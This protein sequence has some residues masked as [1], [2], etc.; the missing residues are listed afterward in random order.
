MSTSACFLWVTSALLGQLYHVLEVFNALFEYR[1]DILTVSTT[2]TG[3]LNVFEIHCLV[4]GSF[5]AACSL[6]LQINLTISHS[7]LRWVISHR[8]LISFNQLGFRWWLSSLDDNFV[9]VSQSIVLRWSM[10]P[11][12]NLMALIVEN[13]IR[14]IVAVCIGTLSTCWFSFTGQW[15]AG[16]F[17]T[18]NLSNNLRWRFLLMSRMSSLPSVIAFNVSTWIA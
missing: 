17:M 18:I 4:A 14:M 10:R 6:M 8:Y 1:W 9:W 13:H 5:D 11:R 15:W 16:L 12:R 7:L 3:W 2:S